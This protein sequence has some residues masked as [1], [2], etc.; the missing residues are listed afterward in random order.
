[1][2]RE[3]LC[4]HAA[5][6]AAAELRRARGRLRG[7]DP[8]VACILEATALAVAEGVAQCLADAAEREPVLAAALDSGAAESASRVAF[9]RGC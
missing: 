2:T 3:A 7:F 1:M 5:D 9:A 8:T 6:V 4:E